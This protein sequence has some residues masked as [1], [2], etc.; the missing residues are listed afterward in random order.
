VH[1]GLGLA[2]VSAGRVDEAT[3]EFRRAIDLTPTSS[4]AYRNLGDV[5][6]SEGKMQEALAALRRA[7]ELSPNDPDTRV[8]LARTLN[9][10]GIALG[11]R[12]QFGE[13]IEKFEQALALVPGFA[14]AQHN[15][16]TALGAR[17]RAR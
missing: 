14:Q 1:N 15:L 6:R 7:V 4:Q 10:H 16:T 5:L 13:A 2:Y 17:E 9:D 8:A 11:S 3:R 12:G